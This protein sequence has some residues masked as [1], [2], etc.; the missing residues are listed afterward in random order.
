MI[1]T[2]EVGSFEN[3][4]NMT[5]L[6]LSWNNITDIKKG[7][8][9]EISYAGILDLSYNQLTNFSRVSFIFFKRNLTSC[10]DLTL[11]H[12]IFRFHLSI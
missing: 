10:Y 11:S 4:V 9:D 6:D 12:F 2:I 8:F 3:C 7:T 5:V 1:D